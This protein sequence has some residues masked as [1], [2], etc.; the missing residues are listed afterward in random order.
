MERHFSKA[1]MSIAALLLSPSPLTA[2][3][4]LFNLHWY[5]QDVIAAS[6]VG[7][8]TYL[9]LRS[10][11]PFEAEL[12]IRERSNPTTQWTMPRPGFD[13]DIEDAQCEDFALSSYSEWRHKNSDRVDS[14][15]QWR[16]AFHGVST[17]AGFDKIFS[18]LNR[19]QSQLQ[20]D[21]PASPKAP[22]RLM[23][24]GDWT[25]LFLTSQPPEW[26]QALMI[27]MKP[28]PIYR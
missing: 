16:E 2:G 27:C 14:V 10:L 4:P 26:A 19:Q 15:P 23:A 17:L 18:A 3:A 21:I 5:L 22:S 11:G 24:Q 12:L 20:C 8:E 25:T 7:T 28:F 6:S 9:E 13:R 1:L